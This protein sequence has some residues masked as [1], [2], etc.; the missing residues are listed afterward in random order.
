MT[1]S[2]ESILCGHCVCQGKL[3]PQTC[4]LGLMG[5]RRQQHP[6]QSPS[7]LSCGPMEDGKQVSDFLIV[8]YK[9]IKS[10]IE[11]I[12]FCSGEGKRK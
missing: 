12:I 3:K 2:S 10:L 5:R 8:F 6:L 7:T 1:S 4:P 11:I 9:H